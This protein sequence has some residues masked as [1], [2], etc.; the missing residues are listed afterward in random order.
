[1]TQNVPFEFWHFHQLFVLLRVP[2][3]VT[4]FDVKLQFFKI[5]PKLTILVEF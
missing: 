1:M 4:L 3:L 2:Y 5:L